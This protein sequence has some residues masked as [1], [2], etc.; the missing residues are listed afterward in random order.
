MVALRGHVRYVAE[1]HSMNPVSTMISSPLLCLN[2]DGVV[3]PAEIVPG[4]EEVDRVVRRA[5]DQRT[6]RPLTLLP[7]MQSSC[8]PC[9]GISACED[10]LYMRHLCWQQPARA[11]NLP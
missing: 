3:V 6:A 9:R 1:L 8:I 7:I 5:E 4:L 11:A 10:R 2:G